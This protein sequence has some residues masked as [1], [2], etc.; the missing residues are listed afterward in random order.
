[1]VFTTSIDKKNSIMILE[2]FLMFSFPDINLRT[3][4]KLILNILGLRIELH[5]KN[6]VLSNLFMD[7]GK[8]H[9][10]IPIELRINILTF[11]TQEILASLSL[12]LDILKRSGAGA[13]V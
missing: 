7:R 3:N 10:N 11:S 8:F 13:F 4:F 5:H 9:V 1:M 12:T 2:H 6:S